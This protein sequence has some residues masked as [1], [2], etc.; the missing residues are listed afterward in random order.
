M[1]SRNEVIKELVRI[2]GKEG[3]ETDELVLRLYTRDAGLLEGKAL[4]VVFPENTR[5]VS[6]LVRYAYKHDIKLIP[7]GG[8]T[9]LVGA[10]TPLYEESILINMQR[11]NKLKYYNIVDSY[12][13]AEPGIRLQDLNDALL[14][15]GYMFPV[16]PASVKSATL[17]GAI[18]SGAGGMRGAKYGT[19][20]EWI[21]QLEAVIPDEKGSVIRV[22]CKTTKCRQGYDLV[23]LIVGSEGTLAIVTEAVVKI[24]PIPDAVAIALGFFPSLKDLMTTVVE[25]KKKKYYPYIMEFLDEQTAK[26]TVETMGGRVV[27]EGHML[28]VGIDTAPEAVDRIA[29][30]LGTIMRSNNARQVYTAKS[31]KEAE[32][33]GLFDL[34]RNYYPASIKIASSTQKSPESRIFVFIEDIAVPPSKLVDAVIAL[35]KLA[36]KYNMPL[37]LGGHVGDGNLH[38]IS[39]FDLSDTEAREK[40]HKFY[41]DIMKLAI[42]MEGTMSCEHGIGTEKK[43][44]LKIE[45]EA[46]G[47]T[48]P[49]DLMKEIKRIFD[50]KNI[51]NPGKVV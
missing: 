25:I 2:F 50:P 51:L 8:S 17:G 38:P 46:L 26:I 19:M 16:D 34:R 43:E 13:V 35:R 41:I 24:T 11:M 7:Q 49:L 28:L 42:S 36:E 30:E 31:L 29:S 45:F 27:G 1:V 12:A 47:S 23:R 10:T 9:E 3:V 39:W 5:Q 40:A 48:R 4:A 20:K 6:E 22:G 32:E 18:N 44:G 37:T 15:E 33:R 21:M 14:K